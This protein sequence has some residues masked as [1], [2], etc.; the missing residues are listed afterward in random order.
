MVAMQKN[1]FFYDSEMDTEPCVPLSPTEEVVAAV[2]E[3]GFTRLVSARYQ[4]RS[5]SG[6]QPNMS[7]AIRLRVNSQIKNTVTKP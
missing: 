6:L 7:E 3:Y 2:D 1:V 5:T 4:C